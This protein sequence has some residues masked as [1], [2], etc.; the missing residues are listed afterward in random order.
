MYSKSVIDK[1]SEVA[2]ITQTL[3]PSFINSM[4]GT[5]VF[6]AKTYNVLFF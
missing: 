3:D 4:M 1:N 6:I 2:K 5:Y